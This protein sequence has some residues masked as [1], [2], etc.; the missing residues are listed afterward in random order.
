MVLWIAR[1]GGWLPALDGSLKVRP[2]PLRVEV[3]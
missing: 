2:L 1:A 3:D